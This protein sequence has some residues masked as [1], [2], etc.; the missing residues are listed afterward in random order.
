VRRLISWLRLAS[1]L[2][3]SRRS[4]ALLAGCLTARQRRQWRWRG[5]FEVTGSAGG[6]YRVYTHARQLN[7]R[8]VRA[9][10]PGARFC[11]WLRDVPVADSWLAQK[12]L[13]EADERRFRDGD[14]P[15]YE[16]HPG[17]PYYSR[18]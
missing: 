9:G 5:W 14:M 7:I 1:P 18:W 13:I 15:H 8:Q 4:R 17:F 2:P 12:L 16:Y 11:L 3:A 10:I 6:T